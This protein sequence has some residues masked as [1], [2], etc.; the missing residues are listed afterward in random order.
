MNRDKAY[1][2]MIIIFKNSFISS[3]IDCSYWLLAIISLY[4]LRIIYLIMFT[5]FLKNMYLNNLSVFSNK[6]CSGCGCN[7][8]CECKDCEECS[9]CGGD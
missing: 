5:S 7:C 2:K 4:L 8:P 6:V 3:I 9:T 1:L